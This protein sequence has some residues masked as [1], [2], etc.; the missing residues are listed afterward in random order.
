MDTSTIITFVVV[1]VAVTAAIII[2][3]KLFARYCYKPRTAQ[4]VPTQDRAN[5]SFPLDV[6]TILNGTPQHQVL[7]RQ[8]SR[9]MPVI[10]T[11]AASSRHQYPP[12]R[13][14]DN[15]AA[16]RPS[17]PPNYNVVLSHPSLYRKKEAPVLT[18]LSRQGT[19]PPPPHYEDLHLEQEDSEYYIEETERRSRAFSTPDIR[20]DRSPGPENV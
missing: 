15:A 14:P 10:D 12:V 19:L 16:A 7:S 8:R 20:T 9:S 13:R 18:P 2:G 6:I 3:C 11:A 1:W 5:Q 4:P 17:S